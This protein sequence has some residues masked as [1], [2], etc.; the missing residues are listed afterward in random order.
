MRA[1]GILLTESAVEEDLKGRVG[2]K[3]SKHED[4]EDW[5]HCNVD[6]RT[7]EPSPQVQASGH[8]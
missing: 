3:L 8:F 5:L 2:E 7:M 4:E 1:V 6:S